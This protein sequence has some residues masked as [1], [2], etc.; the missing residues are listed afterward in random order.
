MTNIDIPTNN[1]FL[2]SSVTP[3]QCQSS[4]A[5]TPGCVAYTI[6]CSDGLN[7]GLST[8]YPYCG[9]KTVLGASNIRQN[10]QRVTL[11]KLNGAYS[12]IVGVDF[13]GNNITSL[14]G[15]IQDCF[16]ACDSNPAC[17]MFTIAVGSYPIKASAVNLCYLKTNSN[18]DWL[19]NDGNQAYVLPKTTTSGSHSM[20]T[21]IPCPAGERAL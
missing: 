18:I 7:C 2:H 4:C 9:G 16:S 5:S 1:I 15:T 21:C 8:K 20:F 19:F 17:G 12:P 11:V 13:S 3:L 6:E 10:S 14:S